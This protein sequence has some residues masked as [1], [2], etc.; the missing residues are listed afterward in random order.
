MCLQFHTIRETLIISEGFP[1]SAVSFLTVSLFL[2]VFP[3]FRRF[4]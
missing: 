4:R 2:K 1:V 3:C